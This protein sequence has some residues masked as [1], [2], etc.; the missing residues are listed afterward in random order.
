M[1]CPN[2]ECPDFLE[3]GEPGEYRDDVEICPK[4]GARLEHAPPE[5][6]GRPGE[7]NEWGGNGA[8]PGGPLVAVAWFEYRQDADLAAS[9]LQ[10]NGIWAVVFADDG[11]GTLPHVGFGTAARVMV[12]EMHAAAALE[13]LAQ[14]PLDGA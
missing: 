10:A 1:F 6:G 5:P 13:L 3:S 7:Q 12:P 8:A 9:M 2:R 11:G 14:R 4:C